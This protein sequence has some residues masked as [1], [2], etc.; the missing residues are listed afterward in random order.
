MDENH[1][2]STYDVP[3]AINTAE[4]QNVFITVLNDALGHYFDGSIDEVHIYN[5]ALS[6][7]DI[8]TLAN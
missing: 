6:E 2:N 1:E 3:Q 8:A 5:R 7:A 4:S